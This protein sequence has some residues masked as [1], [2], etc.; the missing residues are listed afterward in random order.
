MSKQLRPSARQIRSEFEQR[1]FSGLSGSGTL[2]GLGF[3]NGRAKMQDDRSVGELKKRVSSQEDAIFDLQREVM[4]AEI[5][6]EALLH[7]HGSVES[8]KIDIFEDERRELAMIDYV[9]AAEAA[10]KSLEVEILHGRE[11]VENLRKIAGNELAE[12][13]FLFS[14]IGFYRGR[15]LSG[16]PSAAGVLFVPERLADRNFM[17]ERKVRAPPMSPLDETPERKMTKSMTRKFDRLAQ[18][19]I[20]CV[21]LRKRQRAVVTTSVFD[22]LKDYKGVSENAKPS[23]GSDVVSKAAR[24]ATVATCPIRM[25]E[26]VRPATTG[27]PRTTNHTASFFATAKRG[28][29]YLV[30][31]KAPR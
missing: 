21:W 26:A 24:P 2:A 10:A 9:S 18:T 28:S 30:T 25:V 13:K 17:D 14:M 7:E 12:L 8:F 5:V 4:D 19:L 31:L 22:K 29:P 20:P 23:V 1:A 3:G 11:A 16:F 27:R 15:V 6:R